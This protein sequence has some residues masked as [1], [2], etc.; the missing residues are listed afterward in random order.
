[1]DLTPV[2][3]GGEGGMNVEGQFFPFEYDD[4]KLY[5]KIEKPTIEDLDYYDCFELTSPLDDT[6][7][8]NVCS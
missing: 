7:L 1:M 8:D 6:L 2:K 5:F 3:H 4:E